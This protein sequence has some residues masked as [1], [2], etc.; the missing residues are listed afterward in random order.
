MAQSN[1]I[2]NLVHYL[3]EGGGRRLIVRA[4]FVL[5]AIC[6][7]L[8]MLTP[9]FTF[10]PVSTQFRGLSSAD[11]MDQAQIA[12]QLANGEGFSTK[13]VRP[14]AV[15]ELQAH[16]RDIPAGHLPVLYQAPLN[17]FLNSLVFRLT[18]IHGAMSPS[19][20]VIFSGDRWIAV[21]AT[22][23]LLLS[24]WVNFLI[25]RRLFD[26]M[27]AG[28]VACLML[29]CAT[30]WAYA[31]SG[32]PQTL[33]LLLFSVAMYF[34]VRA[35]E[36]EEEEESPFGW[37]L[38]TAAMFGLLALTHALTLWIFAG[39]LFF[40]G[41]FFRSRAK[42]LVSMAVVVGVIYAPWLI[43]NYLVCGNATGLALYTLFAEGG[44]PSV[45][46]LMSQDSVSLEGMSLTLLRAKMLGQ[47][48]L[49][50]GEFYKLI[51]YSVVAP[52]FFVALLH[53]FKGY[54]NSVFRWCVLSMFAFAVLGMLLFGFV[55]NNFE[56]TLDP[57]NLYIVLMP[58]MAMYGLAFVLV[59]WLRLEMRKR[60]F[61]YTLVAV[62]VAISAV[63]LLKE[64][65]T[66]N[67]KSVNWPPYVPPYLALTASWTEPNEILVSDM[68]WA[69]AWYG[70][71]ESLWLPQDPKSLG[72][73]SLMNWTQSS[74][75]GLLLTPIT[76]D[77]P[78]MSGVVEGDY[79]LWLP[80]ILQA[81]QQSSLFPAMTQMPPPFSSY[82]F[83]SDRPRWNE[84]KTTVENPALEKPANK[85][86]ATKAPA[87]GK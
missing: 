61:R 51:G 22:I 14:L 75:G 19:S 69:T 57:N 31:L 5:L 38:A 39:F 15:W 66:S 52:V 48:L 10:G 17:P 36:R 62:I 81:N 3:E 11:G 64:V 70:D 37:L 18:K 12:R 33:I 45:P 85:K 80:Y 28:F 43:R 26:R 4:L 63:P 24:I 72:L 9:N 20:G 21:T 40:C 87:N 47:A 7:T 27:L 79:K 2:Q 58:L 55:G 23:F 76:R 82:I 16:K 13:V 41:F 29:I 46:H 44:L 35:I 53:T 34:T 56:N 84:K 32:L 1:F 42:N 50:S 25:A 54:V 30:L 6:V 49:Q 74:V 67:Q 73:V 8:L 78:L 59:L 83:Y 65:L 60:M 86:S 68:P 71:R 77:L